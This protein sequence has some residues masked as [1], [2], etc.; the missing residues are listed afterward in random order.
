MMAQAFVEA[1]RVLKPGGPLIIVYAHKTTQGWST[2][3][4][5]L[6]TAG[7]MVTE[8]WPLDTEMTTRVRAM[9]TASLASSIFLVARRRG[10]D[11]VGSYEHQVRPNPDK[12]EPNR[13]VLT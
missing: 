1:G 4:D 7:F 8:A 9:E 11:E 6:R 12:P 10:R 3:V 5:A 13:V 2:L